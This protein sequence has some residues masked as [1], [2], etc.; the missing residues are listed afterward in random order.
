MSS[1]AMGYIAEVF[2]RIQA[3]RVIFVVEINKAWRKSDG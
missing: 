2:S 3:E 1:I